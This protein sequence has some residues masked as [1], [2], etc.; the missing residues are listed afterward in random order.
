MRAAGPGAPCAQQLA[1]RRMQQAPRSPAQPMRAPTT[2][3]TE[4]VSPLKSS[5]S[6]S[7]L[8]PRVSAISST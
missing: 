1:L 7:W 3:T 5:F 4:K 6:P 2:H 8:L